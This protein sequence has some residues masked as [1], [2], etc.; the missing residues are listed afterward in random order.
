MGLPVEYV[1]LELELQR[2]FFRSKTFESLDEIFSGYSMGYFNI[3]LSKRKIYPF[4]KVASKFDSPERFRRFITSIF[5][6]H[7]K[8]VA[9]KD[10]SKVNIG[11]ID[12]QNE[13]NKACITK[14]QH[15][16]DQLELGLYNDVKTIHYIATGAMDS[17]DSVLR[18]SEIFYLIRDRRVRIE[19]VALL[20]L[21]HPFLVVVFANSTAL[22]R[23]EF[24]IEYRRARKLSM[25]LKL[26]EEQIKSYEK[27]LV[28]T[29]AKMW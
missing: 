18:S 4:M 10:F 21:I 11:F 6:Y 13:I 23:K 19:S 27:I 20:E 22:E 2:I 24:E 7:P 14:H 15:N 1:N 16:L 29:K 5:L 12:P 3:I 17:F 28:D 8:I 25:L 9:V 26:P